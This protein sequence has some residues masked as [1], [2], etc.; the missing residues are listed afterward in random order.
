[1]FD[2]LKHR[3]LV[4]H[5][6]RNEVMALLDPGVV[7]D[8]IQVGELLSHS[9]CDITDRAGVRHIKGEISH[10]EVRLANR[11]Q[12]G[13]PSAADDDPVAEFVER[14]GQAPP[15]ARTSPRDEDCVGVHSH[16]MVTSAAC[17]L[18]IDQTS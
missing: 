18:T 8:A 9:P 13:F 4:E 7:E 1:V 12:N 11:L 14:L 16:E 3:L 5:F 10:P 2:L 6:A 15:D 17:G